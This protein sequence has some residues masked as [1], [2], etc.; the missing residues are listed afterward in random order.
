MD[1]TS[2]FRIQFLR[3]EASYLRAR[4]ALLMAAPAATRRRF[5]AVARNDA[6]RI[7]AREY[8]LVGSGGVAV[9]RRDRL[10]RGPLGPGARTHLARAAAGFD[11]AEMQLYAAVTR[12][13]L[14][15]L[16]KGE[17]GR[18]LQR[19]SDE[20]MAAQDVRNPALLTRMLAPGFPDDDTGDA[21]R[22]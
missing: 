5:L 7:A 13:R 18:E 3:I 19:Q 9:E 21:V 10:R 1:R 17:R 16:V 20:W 6:R 11:R 12:R 4:C 8:G 22:G 15:A 14:G 2:L